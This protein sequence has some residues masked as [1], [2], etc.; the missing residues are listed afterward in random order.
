MTDLIDYAGLFP[1]AALELDAAL[2]N[3]A[4][5]L[6]VQDAWMLARFIIPAGRLREIAPYGEAWF[7]KST[8]PWHLSVIVGGGESRE[9][10]LQNLRADLGRIRDLAATVKWAA[11]DVLE[12]RLL[13]ETILTQGRASDFFKSLRATIDETSSATRTL[14]I[15]APGGGDWRNTDR[16][17]IRE[18]ARWSEVCSA[19]GGH[20]IG[21]KLRCGGPKPDDT[22]PTERVA[23]VIAACRDNGVPFKCTAGLHNPIRHYTEDVGVMSHGFFNI[24]GASI[25][26]HAHKATEQ[27][28]EDCINDED[29]ENFT[30]RN[31]R[32]VWRGEAVRADE[33]NHAR[34]EF[35][36]SF[37]SC[38]F[39]EPR[40]HLKAFGLLD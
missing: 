19:D 26:A 30:F 4:R 25:M 23:A 3:Y 15:E 6:Q 33:I 39:D 7:G 31:D 17:V 1:P 32:F 24:I 38:S 29:P 21:F 13:P 20:R 18:L 40:E 5:Y 11:A 34:R 37:G 10:I 28:L 2:N 36:I 35:M 8:E 16:A 9:E 14:F 22:P 27:R 12:M